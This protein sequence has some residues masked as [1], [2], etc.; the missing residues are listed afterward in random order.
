M[1]NRIKT[2]II[3]D[4]ESSQKLLRL[5]IEDYCPSLRLCG[6]A[7]SVE[8]G[9]QLIH[10]TDID[11]L[12]LDI[13]LGNH[14]SF[15]MLDKV[16]KKDFKIIFT[17][18]HDEYALKAFK[19]EAVDYILKPFSPKD[20]L[21]A[22]ERIK[23]KFTEKRMISKLMTISENY[24]PLQQQNLKISIATADGIE[25]HEAESITRIEGNGSYCYIIFKNGHKS[26]ASKSLKEVE[27]SLPHHFFRTH[28]SHI[29]NL[30]HVKQFNKL[31]GGA[32]I[33]ENNDEVPVS[34][35]KKQDFLDALKSHTQEL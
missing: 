31:D 4:E 11:L 12:F 8:E 34:R 2:V 23:D 13:N 22:V 35:R 1:P 28:D 17:T 20:I 15:E 14:T 6:I 3:E 25:L 9:L 16:T 19:Y 26:L 32:V 33:L 27:S 10:S 30:H 7:S 18:A 29:I 21:T 5:I 24:K